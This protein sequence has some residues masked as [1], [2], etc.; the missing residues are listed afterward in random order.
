MESILVKKTIIV[1]IG[2]ES[3]IISL[4]NKIGFHE[5]ERKV[6]EEKII[7]TFSGNSEDYH[8]NDYIK[9]KTDLCGYFVFYSI[10]IPNGCFT[11]SYDIFKDAHDKE[12]KTDFEILSF[13]EN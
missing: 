7:I 5:E 6:T 10:R 12:N 13:V 4:M 2:K 9:V 1:D 11:N 3:Y 8:E